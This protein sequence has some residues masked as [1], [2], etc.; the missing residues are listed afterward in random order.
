MDRHQ[1][2]NSRI[3]LDRDWLPAGSG[4]D[5]IDE[6]RVEHH[7]A[8]DTYE[9]AAVPAF[10]ASERFFH[11]DREHPRA[12][13]EWY[14]SGQ[15]GDPPTRTQDEERERVL[16]PL[17]QHARA[18]H[19]ALLDR[20][21]AIE[22]EF[23]EHRQE[24]WREVE[25]LR[26]TGLDRAAQLRREAV[27]AEQRVASADGLIKW[28]GVTAGPGPFGHQ[29]S[30]PYVTADLPQYEQAEGGIETIEVGG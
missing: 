13:R 30:A 29:P 6:L 17:Q 27:Q 14:A 2:R 8:L 7:A 26:D 18:A 23:A 1:E 12:L 25:A 15:E 11:E 21:E 22:R 4:I 3:I 28:I 20:V 5:R 10:E 24:W 19:E 16:A 9:E